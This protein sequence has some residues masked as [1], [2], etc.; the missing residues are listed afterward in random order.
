MSEGS[1]EY[2]TKVTL[3]K[4]QISKLS[5]ESRALIALSSY[6]LNE[7]NVF[8]RMYQMS[9]HQETGQEPIDELINIQTNVILRNWS[10]KMFEFSK[11]LRENSS[12]GRVFKETAIKDIVSEALMKFDGLSNKAGVDLVEQ[13]RNRATHHY[14]FFDT[15][16]LVSDDAEMSIFLHEMSGNCVYP[17]GESVFFYSRLRREGE[18]IKEEN[19]A[20][21][22]IESWMKWNIATTKWLSETHSLFLERLVFDKLP[23]LKSDESRVYLDPQLVAFMDQPRLPVISRRRPQ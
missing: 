21:K 12:K 4:T 7:V 13:L 19:A 20:S 22:L 23:H 15:K 17:Y 11:A 14:D 9:I 1:K 5:V 6:A 10:A 2:F 16:G 3:S 18:K 8:L